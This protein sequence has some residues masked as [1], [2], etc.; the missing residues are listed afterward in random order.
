MESNYI[1][2]YQLLGIES[3]ASTE[4]ILKAYKEKAKEY[5]PDKN[6]GHHTATKLF[7]YIQ[8][9]KAVLIDPQQ[10]LEYDFMIGV[11]KRP[12]PAPFISNSKPSKSND[13][14]GALLAAGAVGLLVGLFLSSGSNNH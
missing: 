1:T 3:N 11:K 12:E 13:N 2:Y 9:A 6:D 5:H 4:E 7:Q 10:R 14:L 8:D